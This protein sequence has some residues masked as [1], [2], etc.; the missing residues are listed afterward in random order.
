MRPCNLLESSVP[1]SETQY[2]STRLHDVTEKEGGCLH[3]RRCENIKST[4]ASPNFR[5]NFLL[6]T[7][8][9]PPAR[10]SVT[11]QANMY[12]QV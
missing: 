6:H 3:I 10:L 2:I 11:K 8:F 7:G 4:A 9:I 1:S 5:N 12:L